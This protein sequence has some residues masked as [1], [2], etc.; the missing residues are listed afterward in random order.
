MNKLQINGTVSAVYC[1]YSTLYVSDTK[2]MIYS[3]DKI[4]NYKQRE[5]YECKLKVIW[6]TFLDKGTR[7]IICFTDESAIILDSITLAPL[8]TIISV[9]TLLHLDPESAA[10]HLRTYDI[11]KNPNEEEEEY[12]SEW[13]LCTSNGLQFVEIDS[14]N[15]TASLSDDEAPITFNLG[16]IID[17]TFMR[18]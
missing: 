7:K 14:K 13:A 4:Y 2:G 15:F 5:L 3:F 10:T 1:S 8:S 9:Q 17:A 12:L 16:Q 6:M 11:K 18:R